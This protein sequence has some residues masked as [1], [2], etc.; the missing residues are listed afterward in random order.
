[1]ERTTP[2]TDP[3]KSNAKSIDLLFRVFA[4]EDAPIEQRKKAREG[5]RREARRALK[6]FYHPQLR[7]VG[8]LLERPGK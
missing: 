3:L 7:E 1:M 8:P 6:L 2:F 5:L 4:D